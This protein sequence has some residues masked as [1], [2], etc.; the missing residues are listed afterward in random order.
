MKAIYFKLSL[1][2]FLI[3]LR[4]F[5]FEKL[6]G[7]K[8]QGK[9][10]FRPLRP[11]KSGKHW[12]SIEGREERLRLSCSFFSSN[13]CTAFLAPAATGMP[14]KQ[15][16]RKKQ[17]NNLKLWFLLKMSWQRRLASKQYIEQWPHLRS[18]WEET[19]TDVFVQK[20]PQVI[21]EVSVNDASWVVKL[22]GYV[23]GLIRRQ[24]TRG[25]LKAP[26]KTEKI[27]LCFYKF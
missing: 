11:T 26:R 14:A 21:R 4:E 10:A 9:S 5:E 13:V 15:L 3:T 27:I 19:L 2:L 18:V 8:L 20:S 16:P 17:R 6:S 24:V 12:N 7:E 22:F 1:R 25:H 23:L